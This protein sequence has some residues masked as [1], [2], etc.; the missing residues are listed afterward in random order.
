M[1]QLIE[2]KGGHF[3]G[4]TRKGFN[5]NFLLH[6]V[7]ENLKERERKFYSRLLVTLIKEI[8]D[9]GAGGYYP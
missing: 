9:E 6:L 1:L 2:L 3:L 5:S 7:G 4:D 8:I